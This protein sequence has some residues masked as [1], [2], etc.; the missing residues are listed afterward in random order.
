MNKEVDV[1]P[2]VFS[3]QH[4]EENRFRDEDLIK[5]VPYGISMTTD[6]QRPTLLLRDS[7][8]QHVLPV[9][10]NPLEAGMT[11]TQSNTRV[12]PATPHKFTKLFLDSLNI[13]IERCVFVEIKGSSQ[14][15]RIFLENH[16]S[17]GS[18]K[19]RAD[20]AMSLCL[21][22]NVDIY[23]TLEFMNKSKVLAAEIE[24]FSKNFAFN[25][26]EILKTQTYIQ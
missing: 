23:A 9:A 4:F 17:H 24:Q 22:L 18:F 11:L 7:S 10:L 26:S 19:L 12:T 2:I 1:S 21:Y 3:T 13:K 5:L 25:P 6:P 14:Y 15:V 20:E 8:G 16:P